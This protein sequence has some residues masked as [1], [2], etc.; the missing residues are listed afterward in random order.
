MRADRGFGYKN[1]LFR[2]S[3]ESKYFVK[4]GGVQVGTPMV[5]MQLDDVVF[6]ENGL[7]A[8][9]AMKHGRKQVLL[10]GMCA[11]ISKDL[12]SDMAVVPCYPSKWTDEADPASGARVS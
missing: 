2:V 8:L 6:Y 7:G 3:K 5:V 1:V 9:D 12:N 4:K 11:A 10:K